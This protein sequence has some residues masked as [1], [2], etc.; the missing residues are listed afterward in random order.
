M[1]LDNQTGP[2]RFSPQPAPPREASPPAASCATVRAA[3]PA[4]D[5]ATSGR[6]GLLVE[7]AG[8]VVIRGHFRLPNAALCERVADAVR[9]MGFDPPRPNFDGCGCQHEI[10]YYYDADEI[11]KQHLEKIGRPACST[12]L[13]PNSQGGGYDGTSRMSWVLPGTT[14]HP[15]IDIG[16]AIISAC[17]PD[18]ECIGLSVDPFPSDGGARWGA[19]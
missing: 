3:G 13:P 4:S 10:G 11:G 1:P 14:R 17:Q 6:A 2:L 15:S 19:L 7:F 5:V 18:F 12:Y 9:R 16:N 8:I